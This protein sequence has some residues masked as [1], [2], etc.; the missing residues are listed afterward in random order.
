[1]FM[2]SALCNHDNMAYNPGWE[3]DSP[4]VPGREAITVGVV[5]QNFDRVWA[6]VLT[7]FW[8]IDFFASSQTR[9]LFVMATEWGGD[10][11]KLWRVWRTIHQMVHDRVRPQYCLHI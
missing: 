7:T 2:L 10:V 9:L 1:M 8:A 5:Y 4:L 6:Q 11:S 3:Y